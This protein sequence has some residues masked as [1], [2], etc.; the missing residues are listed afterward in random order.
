MMMK[1]LS[2]EDI[3]ESITVTQ[4]SGITLRG[5]SLLG[6]G[7]LGFFLGERTVMGLAWGCRILSGPTPPPCGDLPPLPKN[8]LGLSF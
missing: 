6:S 2:D 3:R 4:G 1:S 7:V 5:R 8:A